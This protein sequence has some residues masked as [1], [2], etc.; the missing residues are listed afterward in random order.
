MSDDLFLTFHDYPTARALMDALE[1]WFNSPSVAP[2][3]VEFSK[4]TRCK[5]PENKPIHKHLIEMDS[6]VTNLKVA[7][8]EI[9]DEMQAQRLI[10]SLPR[11]W[12]DTQTMLRT[13][14]DE[15]DDDDDEKMKLVDRV[16]RRIRSADGMRKLFKRK[17]DSQGTTQKRSQINCFSC[18]KSNCPYY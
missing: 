14:I 7:G 13:N 15:K 18:G 8:V 11:S 9:R 10:D 12:S 6:L 1:T 2:Q 16:R 17:E 4:Y 3:M 5:M